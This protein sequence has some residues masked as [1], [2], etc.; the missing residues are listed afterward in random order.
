MP[1]TPADTWP[2]PWL[3]SHPQPPKQ[4]CTAS[5]PGTPRTSS[6]PSADGTASGGLAD[7]AGRPNDQARLV[8]TAVPPSVAPRPAHTRPI[9]VSL[10]RDAATATWLCRARPPSPTD[11][12]AR[13][14]E[15]FGPSLT[16]AP[17]CPYRPCHPSSGEGAGA[18]HG[19]VRCMHMRHWELRFGWGHRQSPDSAHS[20]H[21][22]AI[23]WCCTFLSPTGRR[24]P[25]AVLSACMHT[26]LSS[27]QAQ[28][29]DS[30]QVTRCGLVCSETTPTQLQTAPPPP[31]HTLA[32]QKCACM[33]KGMPS[34]SCCPCAL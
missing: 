1:P 34:A 32:L 23:T 18:G 3:P 12:A 5:T 6:T 30:H 8:P 15:Y 16:M 22:I 29:T 25:V 33:A 21:R 10:R 28:G 24:R 11:Y 20:V 26:C 7:G 4:A 9:A 13:S 17:P 2:H 14:L 31:T 19:H 27:D